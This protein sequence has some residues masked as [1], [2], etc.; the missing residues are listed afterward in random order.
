MSSLREQWQVWRIRMMRC[1]YEAARVNFHTLLW[2]HSGLTCFR[3]KIH[4]VWYGCFST[5]PET[6]YWMTLCAQL[7]YDV[8]FKVSTD[9]PAVHIL[10]ARLTDWWPACLA[11]GMYVPCRR[12]A[13]RC[14]WADAERVRG[15]KNYFSHHSVHGKR[16]SAPSFP[17][18]QSGNNNYA[19]H[20]LL[21]SQLWQLWASIIAS[22]SGVHGGP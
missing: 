15:Q 17:T 22:A 4:V 13:A 18:L 14:L 12:G 7:Q 19:F 3:E 16:F 8:L 10:Q 5:E 2:V 20:L 9:R 21:S 11:R 1:C 6:A